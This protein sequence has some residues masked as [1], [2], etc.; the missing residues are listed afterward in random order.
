MLKPVEKQN[1][2]DQVY[3]QLRDDILN[4]SYSPGDRLPS[5]RELCDILKINRSSVREAL[6]R[7][8]QAKLIEIKHGRGSVVLDFRYSAGFDVLSDL[9]L[10]PGK[11]NFITLRSIVELRTVFCVESAKLA[12]LRIQQP[13]LE[14][15]KTLIEKIIKYCKT[16]TQKYQIYDWEFHYTMAIA[17]ENIALLLIYNSVKEIY[18]KIPD[19]FLSMFTQAMESPDIYWKIYDAL[20]THDPEKAKKYCYELVETGNKEFLGLFNPPG[21]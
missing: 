7:L 20:K 21:K 10:Q 12:A 17:S 3:N 11:I 5:E 6:K 2:S 8:E 14:K 9:V 19:Q 4:E 16:D 15:I 13:E 18:L 1:L